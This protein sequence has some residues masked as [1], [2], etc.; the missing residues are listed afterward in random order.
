MQCVEVRNS[1]RAN[2]DNLSVKNC[3]TLDVGRR[4]DDQR[5]ALGPIRAIDRVEP[6]PTIA[7]MDLQPVAVVLQ[8]VRPAGS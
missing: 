8:L 6:H 3:I 5:I 1:V 7:D 4:I 2:P